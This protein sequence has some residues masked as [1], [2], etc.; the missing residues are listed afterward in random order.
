MKIL[1]LVNELLTVCGVSK[2]FYNLLGGLIKYYPG[3]EYYVICGGGDAIE[4]FESLGI[5]VVINNKIRHETRSIKGYIFAIKNIRHFVKKNKIDII[6]SHHHYA[7]SLSQKAV[8]LSKTK[9]IFTNHGILPEIGILNHFNGD[10]IIV[11]NEHVREYLIQ[12]KIRKEDDIFLIRHGFP[13]IK[14][15][16]IRSDRLKVITGGRFVK[17]KYFDEYIKAIANLSNEIKQK[18]EFYIAGDGEEEIKLRKLNNELNAGIIFLGKI[19][20]FQKKMYETN[21]FVF[22]S[23]LIAEGFPTIIVEAGIAENLIITSNFVGL[24]KVLSSDKV[25]IIENG[26][27][28]MLTQKLE[29]AILNFDNH[30]I[31]VKNMTEIIEK[32]FNQHDMIEKTVSLYK[33]ILCCR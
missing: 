13:I 21:I 14:I 5:N 11:V 17:E 23:K 2:H 27:I 30:K 1:F 28:E 3:N 4:K 26:N 25:L 22:T 31:K 10:K 6:H 18:A 8:K 15:N 12:R 32:Y 7:A 19:S 16:K 20:D 29:E 24:D 9:T 33:E